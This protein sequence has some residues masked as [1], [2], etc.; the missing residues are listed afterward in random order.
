MG[1]STE[2]FTRNEL[3]IGRIN[4]AGQQMARDNNGKWQYVTNT[5]LSTVRLDRWMEIVEQYEVQNH[6]EAQIQL[7]IYDTEQEQVIR[8][9]AWELVQSVLNK[10]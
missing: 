6:K 9:S 7:L 5:K 2:D 1:F 8:T 10:S 4:K 3:Y